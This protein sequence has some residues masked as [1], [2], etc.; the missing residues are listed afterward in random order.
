MLQIFRVCSGSEN[1]SRR[2]CSSLSPGAVPSK[3]SHVSLLFSRNERIMWGGGRG[4]GPVHHL[5][6][7]GQEVVRE[8]P[9]EE[10]GG[11]GRK[12]KED[13]TREGERGT[14]ERKPWGES[15]GGRVGGRGWGWGKVTE[16]DGGM[17][18]HRRIFMWISLPVFMRTC[19]SDRLFNRLCLSLFL[20]LYLF[21][22][23]SPS[24][25]L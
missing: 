12:G 20:C 10:R 22:S 9:W 11:W 1:T 24:P 3:P 18:R 16:R 5:L 25:S 8:E 19:L 6:V 15:G 21:L 23:F 14:K 17:E 2:L 13:W 7:V 4:Q